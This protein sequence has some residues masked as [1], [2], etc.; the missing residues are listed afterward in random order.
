MTGDGTI[1]ARIASLTNTDVWAK[2]GVM[3]RGSLTKRFRRI[4]RKRFEKIFEPF[5]R[6]DDAR[7]RQTGGAVRAFLLRT[8]R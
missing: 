8:G 3:I 1:I 4:P 2:A 7:N 5:Y 6:L